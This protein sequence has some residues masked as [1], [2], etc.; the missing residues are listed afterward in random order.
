MWALKYPD[1]Q[2]VIADYERFN[3]SPPEELFPPDLYDIESWYWNAF[4]ELAT[5][6]QSGMSPGPIPWS[7]IIRYAEIHEIR[8]IDI[9]IESIKAMDSVYLA[10]VSESS[11]SQTTM[12]RELFKEI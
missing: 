9:F 12:T 6:R 3:Q 7:S 4:W 1:A 8:D 10:H 2:K 5:D 11:S